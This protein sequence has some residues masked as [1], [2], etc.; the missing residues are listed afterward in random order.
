MVLGVDA[1]KRLILPLLTALE[2]LAGCIERIPENED[3]I[4]KFIGLNIIVFGVVFY[5]TQYHH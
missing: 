3:R 4:W 2:Y 1:M 5:F